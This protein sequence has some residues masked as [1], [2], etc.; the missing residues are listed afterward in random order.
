MNNDATHELLATLE[1]TLDA[2]G[3]EHARWPAERRAALE[4]LLA[5]NADAQ[6]MLREA[7]ALDR[8]MLRGRDDLASPPSVALMSRILAAAQNEKPSR[9]TGKK[10]ADVVAMPAR[11]V[12]AASRPPNQRAGFGRG[13]G[14]RAW[15]AVGMLAASLLLGVYIGGT[16]GLNSALASFTE[17]AAQSQPLERSNLRLPGFDSEETTGDELL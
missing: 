17:V 9:D 11:P 7:A 5:T 3:A 8:V 12:E 15:P 13:E 4:R 14:W 1:R 2:Y 6:A 16:G 10:A